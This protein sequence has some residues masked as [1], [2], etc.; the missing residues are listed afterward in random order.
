MQL[1]KGVYSVACL[2]RHLQ[3]KRVTHGGDFHVDA[4][5]GSFLLHLPNRFN[6][7][8]YRRQG[9]RVIRSEKAGALQ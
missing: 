2:L 5:C 8:S 6:V 7:F 1:D 4:F 3:G 9:G